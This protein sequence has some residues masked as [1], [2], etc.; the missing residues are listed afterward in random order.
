MAVPAPPI[1]LDSSPK[2]RALVAGLDSVGPKLSRRDAVMILGQ[3]EI[4]LEDVAPYVVESSFGYARTRV[5]RTDAYELLVM[6][7]MPG[8]HSVP[9]DHAGSICA[10]RILSGHVHETHYLPARDGLVDPHDVTELVE[11]EVIVDQS[12]GI[13]A[14][15]NRKD[16]RERLVT[17]HVYAPPL[18]ELRR[19][20]PRPAGTTPAAPFVT[21][22][23]AGAPVVAIVGGGFSGTLVAAHLVRRASEGRHPL[24]V[25]L[26]DRQAT[27]GEGPAYRTPDPRHLLNVPASNMS[28]WPD[29][30]TDFLDWARERDGAVVGY[31]FL[32]R[33][34][35][36]E[37]VRTTLARCAASA[38][39]A[40][41]VEVRRVEV[42][43]IARGEKQRLTAFDASTIDA[44]AVVVATGHRPPD[45]PLAGRWRGSRTRY[46]EDPWATLVLSAIRPDE[47]V[48]LLGTGLTAVD[49]II[50]VTRSPRTAPI[51]AVSRRG[52]FPAAHT[53]APAPA[54]DARPWLEPVLAMPNLTARALLHALR[55]EV[56]RAEKE[57]AT[58]RTVVDG[59]RPHTARVWRALPLPEA[60]RFL[61]H[62]R[63][64][65]EVHRHRMAPSIAA[66]V[67]AL[68]QGGSLERVAARFTSADADESG[69]TLTIRPRNGE[70]PRTIRADWVVNCTG[71][72]A[73]S[74][75]VT[76][77]IRSLL[78]A[79]RVELD[80]LGL[81]VRCDEDGRALEGGRAQDDLVV[82]GTLR[83]A[84]LWESTAVP[85]LR[86]QAAKAASSIA[87]RLGWDAPSA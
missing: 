28:A 26:C 84:D 86:V 69:V 85:E 63:P 37:Y 67:A 34:T 66:H 57:G 15:E 74:S 68:E 77:M 42:D 62:L 70:A 11:G 5:A 60:R 49:V 48:V 30:P 25:V 13:H 61:K 2:L 83:K 59:L 43:S 23:Q 46:V 64:F 14:L 16:A 35:Y 10:L 40:V 52:L 7:W 80:P 39:D 33:K 8:Q 27:F 41:T 50:S 47:R 45:D 9:H 54:R 53:P 58:W 73:G 17:L 36:G 82:V 38:G 21:Q 19:F 24:H 44:D 1:A 29:R 65:W 55:A 3:H 75:V 31:D 20:A 18:P 72:G 4:T 6:T 12:E 51:V 78:D 56:R 76:P 79:G 22:P 87:T 71:P 81:G 32:P